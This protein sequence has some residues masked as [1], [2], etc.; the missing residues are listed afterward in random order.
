MKKNL[1]ILFAFALAGFCSSCTTMVN[2]VSTDAYKNGIKSI[3][4]DLSQMGYELVGSSSEEKNE[5]AVSSVSYSRFTGY[6]S[7]MSNNYWTYASYQ[8]VDSANNQ[9][10]FEVKYQ[11]KRS[12]GVDFVD[13]LDVLSCQAS[14]DYQNVCGASG[15]VKEK[16]YTVKDNPDM[17]VAIENK[18]GTVTL[19][20]GLSVVTALLTTIFILVL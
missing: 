1:W 5:V 2:V 17:M 14:K 6:G 3:C 8:F 15:V 16:V 10:A 9:V 12:R 11:L 13:N 4:E 19:A 18:S 20:V 7:A